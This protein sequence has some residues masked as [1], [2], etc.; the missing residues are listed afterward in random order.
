MNGFFI[1]FNKKIR[2]VFLA[3]CFF[4]SA[5]LTSGELSAEADLVHAGYYKLTW[6]S[7]FGN[8]FILEESNDKFFSNPTVL[9]IHN[10]ESITL[11][12]RQ[13]GS[14]YYRIK[15]SNDKLSNVVHVTVEHHSLQKAF[16]FFA[17]GLSLFVILIFVLRMG[18]LSIRSEAG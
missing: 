5:S 10:E 18:H 2:L 14:Y 6:P 15:D 17:L 11:T 13:D 16:A 12:G 1:S 7:S 4:Y 9:R 3:C 8:S